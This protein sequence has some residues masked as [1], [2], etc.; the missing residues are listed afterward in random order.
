MIKM[1]VI[2]GEKFTDLKIGAIVIALGTFDGIHLGHQAV[3]NKTKEIARKINLPCGVYT[4]S[5]HPLKVIKP[6]FAPNSLISPAQK[7]ELLSNFD[8]DYYLEQRFTIEFSQLEY[9]DFILDYLVDQLNVAHIV[10]GEDFTFGNHG[11]GNIKTLKAMGKEYGFKATGIRSIKKDGERISSTRIREMITRGE[12]NKVPEF[13]GR[14]YIL[15]GKVIKGAGRGK[16]LGFPTAN[17]KLAVDYV[18]PPRGVY[19][20]YVKVLE[21]KYRGIANFGFNPTFSGNA[22]SVEVH[23]LDFDREDIYGEKI[24]IELVNFIR[25]EIT[26]RSSKDLVKQIRKDILYTDSL[27]CYN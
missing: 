22:Y 21:R 9:T 4:F 1:E 25:E 17:L 13:L 14:Y 19:A 24:S 7:I 20:C 3:I 16:D 6:A 18:L 26:F 15:S 10:V 8:I 11:E 5:P 27:L 23:I 12:V 2:K